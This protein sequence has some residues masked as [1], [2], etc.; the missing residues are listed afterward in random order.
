MFFLLVH[1]NEN[2]LGLGGTKHLIYF[3]MFSQYH[4]SEAY[5]Y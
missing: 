4:S 2:L 5:I 3:M 1:K